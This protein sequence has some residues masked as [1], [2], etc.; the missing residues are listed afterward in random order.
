VFI[1]FIAMVPEAG[2]LHTWAFGAVREHV[3]SLARVA[4][5]GRSPVDLSGD[6]VPDLVLLD[7][8]SSVRVLGDLLAQPFWEEVGDPLIPDLGKA[9]FYLVQELSRGRTSGFGTESAPLPRE[10]A[11]C[12]AGC[13]PTTSEGGCS[14]IRIR[15]R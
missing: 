15:R 10:P 4:D 5:G 1:A 8:F 14:E 7:Y 12:E 13:P 9:F 11:S 3:L 2:L 6:A